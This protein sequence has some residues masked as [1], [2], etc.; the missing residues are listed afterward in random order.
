VSLNNI[1]P[2]IIDMGTLFMNKR[3]AIIAGLTGGMME[4]LWVSLYSSY[5]SVSVIEIARQVTASLFPFA[6]D[7]S[8]APVLGLGIHLL[9]SLVLAML[10]IAIVLKPVF[11]RY[12]KP[13]IMISSLITLTLVW[14]VNFFIVLP[15]LNPSFISLMPLLV[16]FISKLLFGSVMGW[17]LIK[18]YSFEP[19]SILK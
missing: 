6:T 4:V 2:R 18:F 19:S 11:T 1:I 5:S 17:T 12:G 10:F 9:L 7:T 14:K 15:V 13:G 16:T 8:V 3:I